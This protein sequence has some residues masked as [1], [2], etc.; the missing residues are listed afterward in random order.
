MTKEWIKEVFGC[1]KPVIGMLHLKALPT[2]PKY[3]A[4]GGMAAVLERARKDLHALQDGGIDGIIFCNEFSIPYVA[5]VRPVTVAAMA[6]IIG[7]LKSETKVPYG[8]HVA[9]DPFK[10]FELA[11]AVDAKFVRETFFGTYV[12]DY[13][14][15]NVQVGE[16]ERHRYEVGCENV[17]T[18]ATLIPEGGMSLD[19]REIEQ[20]VKSINHNW[21]PDALLV[22]GVHAG[23]AIDN[24]LLERIRSACDTPAFASNGVNEDTVVDT[25]KVCDGCVVATSLKVD[26]KFYNETDVNRVRRLMEKA[27]AYR[28]TL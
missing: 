17:R 22:F 7:E 19:E 6:R 4:A 3:D 26:G 28:E 1:E 12:G 24:S 18:L 10:T 20:K 5:D 27:K 23:S 11:A 25:L 2:D 16:L 8:V 13:G 15:S 14:F 9:M 21:H